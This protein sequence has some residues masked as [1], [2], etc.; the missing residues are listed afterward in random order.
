MNRLI[1]S[2]SKE[3]FFV[4]RFFFF[5]LNFLFHSLPANTTIVNSSV[6]RQHSALQQQE[7]Y[8]ESEEYEPGKR[9]KYFNENK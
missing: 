7:N 1:H 2:S 5:N 8:L 3:F 9:P 6:K 4:F